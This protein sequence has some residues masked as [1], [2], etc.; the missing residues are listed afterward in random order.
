[1]AGIPRSH[2]VQRLSGGRPVPILAKLGFLTVGIGLV[3]DV[4]EHTLLAH[5]HLHDAALI[6]FSAGEHASHL[7]VLLGMVLVLVGIVVDGTRAAG[8][9]PRPQRS[10]SDALR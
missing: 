3:A 6:G 5:P 1:M 10:P 9:T 4:V 7:L 8:R 2:L